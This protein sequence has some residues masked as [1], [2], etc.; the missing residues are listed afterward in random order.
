MKLGLGKLYRSLLSLLTLPVMKVRVSQFSTSRVLDLREKTSS[1]SLLLSSYLRQVKHSK[2]LSESQEWWCSPLVLALRRS[3]LE[4]CLSPGVWDQ[5]GSIV[6]LSTQIENKYFL[7]EETKTHSQLSLNKGI[8]M[9]IQNAVPTVCFWASRKIK[10][11]IPSAQM[12]AAVTL[13]CRQQNGFH[14]ASRLVKLPPCVCCSQRL[15]GSRRLG[16]EGWVFSSIDVHLIFWGWI[17][18]NLKVAIG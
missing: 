2:L 16:W 7:H 8:L 6:K 9:L 11:Q 17:S 14:V 10:I 12:T 4:D 3:K 13:V 18:F 5:L 15:P 1:A